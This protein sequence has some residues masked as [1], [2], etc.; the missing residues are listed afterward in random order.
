MASEPPTARVAS[1]VLLVDDD[2]G[3]RGALADLLSAEGLEVVGQG[4][5][6][7]DAIALSRELQPDLV[8]L[9]DQ[10]PELTGRDALPHIRRESPGARIL[11]FSAGVEPISVENRPD[12]AVAKGLHP[13]ELL[14]VITGLLA[15]ATR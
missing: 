10:M 12:A 11:L 4:I 1:R 14:R 7:A 15:A 6:G 5:T 8:V 3:I 13:A 2:P 9:D